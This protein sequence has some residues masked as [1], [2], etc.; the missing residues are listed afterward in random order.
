EKS[1]HNIDFHPMVAF[2]DASPLRYAL[3]F[4]PTV[5]VSH[6]RQSWSTARIETTKEGTKILVTVDEEMAT[7]LTSMDATT[8]LVSKAAKVPTGS[9]SIPTAG[10]PAAEVPTSSDVVPTATLVFTTATMV[11]PY[12]RKG[13]E[14]MSMIDGLDRSNETLAKY[15]QEYQQFASELPLERRIEQISD[16]VRYQD[17]YAKK[18]LKDFIPMAKEEAER[19][20][21]KCL[22]LEQESAKK[23]K[24]SDEVPEI[25]GNKMHKAFPLPIIKF[26]L[27]EEVPTASEESSH[28]Q[29]KRDATAMRIT[30]LVKVKE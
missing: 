26:P 22:S 3:T 18:Q 21:R 10:L 23:F 7:V 9:G 16:L 12:R 28:C 24:P 6:I 4:K 17:N 19:L 20:K 27:A 11:T 15:L 29:K 2:V 25:V 5:Y 8:V 13:K 1:K 30:L 14:V